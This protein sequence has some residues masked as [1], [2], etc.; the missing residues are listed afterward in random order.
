MTAKIA[1]AMRK[2]E[3]DFPRPQ[4]RTVSMAEWLAERDNEYVQFI[5][6]MPAFEAGNAE[7]RALCVA[8]YQKRFGQWPSHIQK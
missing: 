1:A 3:Q 5:F 7:T 2:F 8:E 6:Q 4:P